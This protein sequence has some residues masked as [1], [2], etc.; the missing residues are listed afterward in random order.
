MKKIKIF[1]IP[2]FSKLQILWTFSIPKFM[3]NGSKLRTWKIKNFFST[4]HFGV[5]FELSRTDI[6]PVLGISSTKNP[7]ILKIFEKFQ[8]L[9]SHRKFFTESILI[10]FDFLKSSRSETFISALF[11]PGRTRQTTFPV[12]PSW[13][14][15]ENRVSSP[16]CRGREEHINTAVYLTQLFLLIMV[17]R[18]GYDPTSALKHATYKRLFDSDCTNGKFCRVSSALIRQE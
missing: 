17:V 16:T 14:F 5:D 9:R 2:F 15:F 10:I 6:L 11:I 1:E 18:E 4:N 13:W 3:T 12:P 7:N 8:T